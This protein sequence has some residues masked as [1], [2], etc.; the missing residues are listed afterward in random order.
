MAGAVPF[1]GDLFDVAF[2]AN[3]R[4]Y[5][6][7]RKH[8]DSPRRQSAADWLF[9]LATLLLVLAGIALPIIGL[10]ALFKHL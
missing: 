7:L 2:K 8:L 9:L 4:N 5:L 6:L 10:I 1:A 3:R